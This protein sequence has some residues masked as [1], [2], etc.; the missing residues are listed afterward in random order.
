MEIFPN[1]YL[2]TTYGIA[3]LIKRIFTSTR[4]KGIAASP[5][6][7]EIVGA[8]ERAL[9]MAFTGDARVIVRRLMGHFGLRTSLLEQ[10]LPSVTNSIEWNKGLEFFT[11]AKEW[12]LTTDNDPAEASKRCQ[13]DTYGETHWLVSPRLSFICDR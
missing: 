8:L 5:Y 6:V 9:A 11:V 4:A 2:Y 10:G 3:T 12:P 7:I 13:I 1:V